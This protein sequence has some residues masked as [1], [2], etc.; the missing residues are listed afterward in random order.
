MFICIP[1]LFT[2]FIPFFLS[3]SPFFRRGISQMAW[4]RHTCQANNHLFW[5]VRMSLSLVG[6]ECLEKT[7]ARK[8]GQSITL[9][10]CY[11]LYWIGLQSPWRLDLTLPLAFVVTIQYGGFALFIHDEV[12]AQKPQSSFYLQCFSE[13]LYN[14]SPP[15]DQGTHHKHRHINQKTLSLSYINPRLPFLM[16]IRRKHAQ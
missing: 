1:W 14:C 12:I 13:A 4:I 10:N 3:S 8:E 9:L 15:S 6:P 2:L 16:I 7:R 11:Q 5:F